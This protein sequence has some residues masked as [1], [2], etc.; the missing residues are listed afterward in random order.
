MLPSPRRLLLLA[1]LAGL[2][3]TT[4][5]AAQPAPGSWPMAGGD[6]AHTAVAEGPEPPYRVAWEFD[7]TAGEPVASPVLADGRVVV[8]AEESV[9]ALDAEDGAEDWTIDREEGPAGAAVAL[10]GVVA[11]VEGAGEE[12]TVVGVD[13][14]DGGEL[15]TFDLEAD[16]P[17]PLTAAEDRVFVGTARGDVH[18]LDAET[19]AEAWS[20]EAEGGVEGAIAVDEGVAYVSA[21]RLSERAGTLYAIGSEDG[22]EVWRYSPSEVALGFSSSFAV[23]GDLAYVGTGDRSLRALNVEDGREVWAQLLRSAFRP[24]TAPA[25]PGVLVA[26]DQ[27][28]DVYRLDPETG[29]IAWDFRVPGSL[30]LGSPIVSGGAVVVG[31][32]VGQASAIDLDS[33]LLVWRD[34]FGDERLE[35]PAADGERVYLASRGGRVIALEHDPDGSLLAEE[36]PTT[37]FPLRALLNFAAAAAAL[38]A[39]LLLIFRVLL[40]VPRGEEVSE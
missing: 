39:V 31:D 6:P 23:S 27:A 36:S 4:G 35:A 17:G 24:R 34:T 40:P 37:L 3:A 2:L 20:F 32:D 11:F 8:V 14:T 12:A 10:P 18:A 5:A 1:P 22:E 28:G 16:A 9:V 33:G 19:G 21:F 38:F 30:L 26:A 7:T 25:I 29:D 13:P 15:W